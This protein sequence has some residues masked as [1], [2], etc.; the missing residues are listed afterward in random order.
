MRLLLRK[1]DSDSISSRVRESHRA[2]EV[3][4]HSEFHCESSSLL[5]CDYLVVTSAGPTLSYAHFPRCNNRGGV[6]CM[7][8]KPTLNRVGRFFFAGNSIVARCCCS[9][10]DNVRSGWAREKSPSGVRTTVTEFSS[11][12][13]SWPARL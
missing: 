3:P 10:T 1:C 2:V 4:P 13:Q 8:C 7:S 9:S 5:P 11:I 12:R 6:N